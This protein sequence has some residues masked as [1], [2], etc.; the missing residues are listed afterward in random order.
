[1]KE[2]TAIPRSA[3]AI[4]PTMGPASTPLSSSAVLLADAAELLPLAAR[5]GVA[6]TVVVTWPWEVVRP[7]V[8]VTA[9]RSVVVAAWV[10]VEEV[11]GLLVDVLVALVVVGVYEG[12]AHARGK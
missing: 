2:R 5:L 4:P 7:A 10:L 9:P 11:V 8:E 6:P 3:P 1:M 12:S